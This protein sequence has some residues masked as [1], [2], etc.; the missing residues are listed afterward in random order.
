MIREGREELG[1]MLEPLRL[2]DTWDVRKSDAWQISGV[3]YLCRLADDALIRLS[4]EHT[5]FAWLPIDDFSRT[6]TARVFLA[7]MQRWDWERMLCDAAC[8]AYPVTWMLLQDLVPNNLFLNGDKLS[9]LKNL[10]PDDF[11]WTLPPVTVSVI[12]GQTALID[13]HT[14][15]YTAHLLGLDRI[16]VRVQPLEQIDGSGALYR[17][18]HAMALAQGITDITQLADRIVDDATHRL[19]WVTFCEELDRESTK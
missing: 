1:C 3:F 4:D 2:L 14:R 6:F 19:K 13:G 17:R 10:T 15:A 12:D 8:F 18:I 5:G 16:R 9:K 11:T 7:R